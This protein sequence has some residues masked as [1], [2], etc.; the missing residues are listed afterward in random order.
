MSIASDHRLA[1]LG[2]FVPS[3]LGN[4]AKVALICMKST[5][6]ATKCVLGSLP[7]NGHGTD[8]RNSQ[9]RDQ[10]GILNHAG[11]STMRGGSFVHRRLNS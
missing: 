9:E 7:E 2:F 1:A 3:I 11:P 10:K 5:D 6:G 8:Y 4:F